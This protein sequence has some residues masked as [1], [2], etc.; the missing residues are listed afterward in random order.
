MIDTQAIRSKILDLAMRGKLTEQLPEDGTAEEL[1]RQIQAEKQKL[2]K[3]GKIKRNKILPEEEGAEEPHPIP[4][5]WKWVRFGSVTE[6]S[7]GT[8][9]HSSETSASGLIPYFKVSDMNVAGNETHMNIVGTYVLESYSGKIFPAGTIIFPKNGGAALTNKRRILTMDSAVDLNTGGCTPVIP[10]MTDWTKLYL[11]TVDFGGINTG[12]NIPTVNATALKKRLF[13][14]PPLAEQHRIVARIEQAFSALDTIDAL[15]AKYADNLA[16]LK[17]KLIDAAIQGKLTEQKPEDGTAEELYRQIQA[18]KQALIKA[19]K[20]KKE[21][22]LPEISDEEVPFEIPANW[23]WVRLQNV[24]DK[25]TDGSH[26]PPPNTGEGYPVI[27]A[28]NIKNGHI[29]FDNVDRF[30]DRAGFEKENPRTNITNGDVIMGIIGGSIGNVGIYTHDTAVIAQRSIAIIHSLIDNT[31][32]AFVLKS[33][34]IQGF[35][36]VI[37]T[38]SA[39]GG[40]YLGTLMTMLIPLPPLAEKKRIVAK[41]EELLQ[42][43]GAT[44]PEPPP[45]PQGVR[46]AQPSVVR[47]AAGPGRPPRRR[48]PAP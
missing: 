45:S 27:S 32:L 15:Q 44:A 4:D 8:T 38:G 13:P 19:G 30:T 34:Y 26:N 29:S 23:K 5:T 1:Y 3:A 39:Q 18:E 25:I 21:K 7:G 2:I 31:Y 28:K 47:K 24:T 16:V 42:T 17:S 6:I 43:T 10:S 20:I 37:S 40:V 41:L 9:P 35:L 48:E 14:L 22:P 33:P 11:D 46:G 12:S 36:R